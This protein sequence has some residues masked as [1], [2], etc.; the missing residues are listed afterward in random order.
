MENGLDLGG[1]YGATVGRIKAQGGEKARLGMAVLMWIS[2][3][4]LPLQAD[5]MCH[6]IAIRIGSNDLR[7]DDVPTISTL[8]GCCQGLATIEK[9]TSTIRLIHFTL[10][11]YLLTQPDLF[12]RAHSTMAETCLA[13]LNFQEIKDL[14]AGSLPDPR[15][16]PF[17]KYSSLYWGTHMR[18]E[19]SD[20]A[21]AFAL[22]LLDQFDGHISAKI[23]SEFINGKLISQ[24]FPWGHTL[25]RKGF[26]PLHCISYFGIAEVVDTLIKMNRWDVNET[27]GA[28]MTPLI[29][30][31]RHGH[32][33][34][35]KLLL[36]IKHIQPGRRD[37]NSGRTALSWAAGNG[38]E[39]V[40]RLFLG[41]RFVNPGSIGGWWREAAR[42]VVVL[43]GWRY[44][45][46]D[47]SSNNG[48]TP[49]SWAAENGHS[50]IVK[51]LLEQDVHPDTP[52]AE[53]SRTP[54]SVAAGN[55][56]EGIVKLLLERKDVN[57]NSSSK[58]GITPLW[59]A[60]ENGHEGIVKLLLERKDVNPDSSSKSGR[61]PLS[62]AAMRG[63]EG[64][65]KLLLE[66][67][68]VHP[69]TP[70]SYYSQT[71]LSYAAMRGHEGV[72]KLLLERKD[73]HPDTPDSYYS[74]TPLSWAAGNG[75]EG[76]VK[77]LLA[78]KDV[79]PHS[80][81]KSGKTPL[82]LAAENGHHRVVELIQACIPDVSGN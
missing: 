67:K 74:Q 7:S 45:N 3:S 24:E 42:V 46:P 62:C 13:Y 32:E 49:L 8:L 11:E 27:D 6:A 2:H 58:Y 47:S 44:V 33:E 43:F 22:Q 41:P 15:G 79:N 55:G 12:D 50:R 52:D 73:V 71:P 59:Q 16:R 20:G 60:A 54:L 14:S 75:H 5:E 39:G 78:R 66:R 53:Y 9:G 80:L 72:V 4:R 65:V 29:W 34:V 51:L 81:S 28:G 17:L 82:T 70:G 56:H 1:A 30:A 10:Q 38:H 26:S 21:N 36:R 69:D 68:D 57:P 31:A 64:V 25:D 37:A 19:V 40:V 77:L 35:V 18:M 23:L 76:V 48:Q 63:H 61:T